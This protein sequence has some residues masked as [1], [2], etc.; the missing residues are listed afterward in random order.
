MSNHVK[1]QI[2]FFKAQFNR[3]EM[4]LNNR[5]FDLN[6]RENSELFSQTKNY[7]IKRGRN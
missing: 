6:K 4:E 7:L 2:Y 5:K 3:S 1:M